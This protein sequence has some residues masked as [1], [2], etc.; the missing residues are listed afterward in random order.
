MKLVN[1]LKLSVILICLFLI[2]N[3][4]IYGQLGNNIYKDTIRVTDKIIELENFPFVIDSII[5]I[6]TIP[7]NFSTDKFIFNFE[8]QELEFQDDSLL[9]KQIEIICKI[10]PIHRESF[11]K[12][13]PQIRKDTISQKQIITIQKTQSRNITD[14]IFGSRIERSGTI[15][16]GF[17]VG[18]N[19][20]FTL[21]SGL[22]LQ[23]AGQLSDDV[24]VVAVLSDQ[25]SPIQPEGNTR[26]LQEIDKVYIDIKHKYAQATFGDF[27]FT[28]RVG[29]FGLVDKKL[30]GLKTTAIL[31]EKNSLNLSYAT[32]RGKFKSQQF[33]GI[34]GVQGPY[35]LTGE[36]N[37]RDIIVLAGTEKVFIN[38]EEKIRGENY[39][40]TIDYST[41]E[42]FFTPRVVIT[43]ASRIKVD[44]EYSDRKFERNF[45]GSIINSS[46]FSDKMIL[47]FSYYRE[48]DNQDLPIDITLSEDDKKILSQSGNDRLKASKS[49]IKFVGFDSTGRAAGQYRLK[50]TLINGQTF[51]FF[52]FAPGSDSALYN[53]TFSYVGEGK[54]DYARVSLGR[55]RYVG[56]NQ[57]NYSPIIL[58]PMPELKQLGNIYSKLFLTKNFYLEGEL[59]ISSFDKNRFS[60]LDDELNKGKAYSYKIGFDSININFSKLIDGNLSMNYYE[61]K[62]DS[63]FSPISR[64]YEAEYERNWNIYQSFAN[65]SELVRE[66]QVS[67][68][69][70]KFD[71]KLSL[72]RMNKGTIFQSDRITTEVKSEL[73]SKL[74]LN[75]SLSNL[76]SKS[77]N[78][79]SKY[80]KHFLNINYIENNFSP[81]FKLEFENKLDRDGKDTLLQSSFKFYD[82]TFGAVSNFIKYFD[83]NSSFKFRED[84]FPINYALKKESNNY[85]YQIALKLK[86]VTNINSSLDLSF[87]QKKYTNEFKQIGRLNNQSVAIKFLGRGNFLE[88]FIQSDIYYEA[89]SQ[90]SAKLERVFLRVAK[91][92]GQYIYKGDLNNNGIADEFEFEPS[93]FEGD[94]ILTTYPT[95]EL[96]PV[97]DL[98]ASLRI[99]QEFRNFKYLRFAQKFLNPISTETYLRVEENSQDKNEKNVYL[100]RLKTFQNP[101]TTIRGSNL[102]QQDLNLFEYNPDFNILLRFIERRAFSKYSLTDETRFSQEKLIRLRFKPIKEFANQSEINFT[103]NNLLSSNY[104]TRN[105]LINQTN[106]SSKIFYYPYQ[107]VEASLKFEFGK[108]EDK[109]PQPHTN[110]YSNTQEFSLIMMYSQRGKIVFSLERT[111]V[112]LNRDLSYIPFE[113]TRGYFVGKNYIWRVTADYQ[114]ANSIQTSLVYDGRVQGKNNPIH[115]ATAEVR[116]YF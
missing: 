24:E 21:N 101:L 30:Q 109:L 76:N 9:N 73:I 40:Y 35:R 61:R 113:L 25:S 12:N 36:N 86:N 26:T 54:G 52:E 116:A 57:G 102:V 79:L 34:D 89:S 110:L 66:A 105:F 29:T 98:K 43:N 77:T 70:N 22:R 74:K 41:G 112:I 114:F 56:Q 75:Y 3:Q 104:S 11:R 78:Y 67:F 6:K 48:G 50:D 15:S 38:G 99:K 91:G 90:R 85:I 51:Q 100:I 17:S 5:I 39:D 53:I 94:Y 88:R 1:K 108:G 20:D 87:R 42:I 65:T 58:L 69:S 72:G 83:I 2:F 33:N 63:N 96:F 111:E 37:E 92:T 7:D 18:T 81:Y 106:F 4:I 8:R 107:N 28:H 49:G 23:L 31:N 64:I 97:V 59:S 93:K 32:A 47:G 13:I 60:P 68:A 80:Q 16:R 103:K 115:T 84:Y 46:L 55:Y 62:T 45:F 71:T 82:L 44:F 27:Q 19:K 95:D 14:D 10:L